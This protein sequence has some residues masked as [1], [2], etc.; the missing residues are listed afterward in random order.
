MRTKSILR[1]MKGGKAQEH[2]VTNIYSGRRIKILEPLKT[3]VERR[4]K[5]EGE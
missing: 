2:Y 1:R 5:R 3:G 4:K